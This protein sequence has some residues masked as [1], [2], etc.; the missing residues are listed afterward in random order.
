MQQGDH[1]E[2]EPRVFVRE[3]IDRQRNRGDCQERSF[4]HDAIVVKLAASADYA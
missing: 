3:E 2:D 1:R 4:E